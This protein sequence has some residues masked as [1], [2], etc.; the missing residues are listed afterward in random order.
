[1]FIVAFQERIDIIGDPI[2]IP[3][4]NVLKE[5]GHIV[6]LAIPEDLLGAHDRPHAGDLFG[7]AFSAFT[8]LSQRDE[9]IDPELGH[10]IEEFIDAAINARSADV[11]RF[12]D[13]ITIIMNDLD[14]DIVI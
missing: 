9:Q 10:R 14:G 2:G 6:R 7:G 5:D 3:L 12:R 11:G 1:M 4:R 13:N 8:G